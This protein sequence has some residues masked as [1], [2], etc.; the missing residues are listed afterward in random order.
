M[1]PRCSHS[2]CL[3]WAGA[4]F[5]FQAFI[6]EA[7]LHRDAGIGDTW[8]CP[9]PNGYALLMIDV[10]DQGAVYNPR[11]QT[12][13]DGV[14]DQDDALDGVRT[15]QLVGPYILG[16]RDRH[17]FNH[18]WSDTTYIDSYFLLDTRVGKHSNFP[19]YDQLR[20]AA[21]KLGIALHLEPIS[22]VYSRYRFTRFDIVA[23]FLLCVPPLVCAFLLVRRVLRLRR[24]RDIIVKAA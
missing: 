9:L 19:T 2:P 3:I 17:S 5:A 20:G 6:N 15:L 7:V 13:S 8:T 21:Q 16:G 22:T 4:V 14:T 23:L 1:L 18:Q 24:T 12:A 10:S 11:T